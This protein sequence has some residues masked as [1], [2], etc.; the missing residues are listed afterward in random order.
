MMLIIMLINPQDYGAPMHNIPNILN[1][2]L[3]D[4]HVL[5]SVRPGNRLRVYECLCVPET[6][7]SRIMPHIRQVMHSC[8]NMILLCILGPI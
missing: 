2:T 3:A 1:N 7:S 6:W 5:C 8:S 4:K